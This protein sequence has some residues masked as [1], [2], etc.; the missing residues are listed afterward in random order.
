M[1]RSAELTEQYFQFV[2]RMLRRSGVAEADVDDAAQE[3][4]EVATRKLDA[5]EFGRER[6][7]LF[8]TAQLIAKKSRRMR[9]QRWQR[10]SEESDGLPSSAADPETLSLHLERR[11]MLDTIL[12]AM[13][14]EL[15][16]VFVLYELEGLLTREIAELIEKPEGTVASR[17]RRAREIFHERASALQQGSRRAMP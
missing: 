17:L 2:W 14:E 8:K 7:F 9:Y 4:F 1:Q 16:T 12:D 13:P 10:E 5:I 3:V 15:R 6:A 11:R